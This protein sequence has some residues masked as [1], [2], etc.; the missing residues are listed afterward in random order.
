MVRFTFFS[1]F[2]DIQFW[3]GAMAM[4]NC[5][6]YKRT[7]CQKCE[8]FK[9]QNKKLWCIFEWPLIVLHHAVIVVLEDLPAKDQLGP[10]LVLLPVGQGELGKDDLSA[11]LYGIRKVVIISSNRLYSPPP[12]KG[13][14]PQPDP[15]GWSGWW[16]S[17]RTNVCNLSLTSVTKCMKLLY[18]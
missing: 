11:L 10:G 15:A 2:G 8:I 9:G 5:W 6:N 1:S 3:V 16:K 12:R 18:S 14:R 17:W 4:L 7:L 13:L